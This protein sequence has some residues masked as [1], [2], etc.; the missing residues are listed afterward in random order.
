MRWHVDALLLDAATDAAGERQIFIYTLVAD[1]VQWQWYCSLGS[2]TLLD[3]A[4][5]QW[6]LLRHCLDTWHNTITTDQRTFSGGH[7]LEWIRSLCPGAMHP[8]DWWLS[9][10]LIDAHAHSDKVDASMCPADGL[11]SF[12]PF[13]SS[14][15]FW[16][17]DVNIDSMLN[18][19]CHHLL[20]HLAAPS[21]AHML[22]NKR[23]GECALASRRMR[24]IRREE[25]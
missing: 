12:R 16:P 13:S 3:F 8:S 18:R 5:L 23:E 2:G 22:R 11:C 7:C 24:W 6:T 15:H 21:R 14:D 4:R 1:G 20:F 25:K 9:H 19:A 17:L 10:V